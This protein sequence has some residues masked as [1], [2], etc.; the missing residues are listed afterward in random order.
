MMMMTISSKISQDWEIRFI[1]RE[2]VWKIKGKTNIY[3]QSFCEKKSS[4]FIVSVSVASHIRN[5]TEEKSFL[6]KKS[7]FIIISN[8]LVS[9]HDETEHNFEKLNNY[10]GLALKWQQVDC[11]RVCNKKVNDLILL[12]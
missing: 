2:R 9:F 10:A 3:L 12:K 6:L 5:G 1:V 8:L 7:T 4:V 11:D